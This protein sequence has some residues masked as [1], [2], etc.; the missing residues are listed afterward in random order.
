MKKHRAILIILVP[1]IILVL[2]R[3]FGTK[4]F[5][6]D[7]LKL[8]E[9]SFSMSNMITPEK[10]SGLEGEKLLV[11]F[12]KDVI[13]HDFPCE[14]LSLTP[15]TILEKKN[16]KKLLQHKGPVLLSSPEIS[17]SVRAWM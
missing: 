17:V 6:T 4:H 7:A 14:I 8:A 5:R 15:V 13:K 2:L 9:P 16:I 12:E 11:I 1:V 10:A 3:S